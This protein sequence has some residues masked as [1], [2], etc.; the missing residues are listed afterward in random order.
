MAT[1][2]VTLTDAEDKALHSVALSAQ[3]WI[4][5][6]VKERCRVAMAEIVDTHVQTQLAAG[7]PLAGTTHEE[8]VLAVD[9]KSV[10]EKNAELLATMNN[11][12]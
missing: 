11:G 6:S 2:T 9:V 8:I 7:Q 5:N 3:E 4:T 1:Y 10:A 12:Q